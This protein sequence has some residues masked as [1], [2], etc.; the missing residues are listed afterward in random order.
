LTFG[1]RYT[2]DKK[3]NA[4]EDLLMPEL[5]QLG[6]PGNPFKKSW[7]EFTPKLG[8][9]Y[10]VNDDLMFY[11]LYSRGFRAGGFSGRA[12]TYEAASIPYNPE[13]VDNFELGMKSEWLNGRLRFNATIFHMEY[14]DKQEEGSVPNSQGTGQQTVV[15][16]AAQATI[17]GIEIDFN[18][19]VSETFSLNGNL[20]LLDAKFDELIDP[21]TQTDLSHLKLRRAPDLTATIEPVLTFD[22][23][24]GVLQARA[25]WHYVDDMEYTILNSPQTQA[26]AHSTVDASLIYT[27]NQFS[28]SL[29]ALNLT[30]D[31]SWQQGY[32]VGAA[33][34]FAGLWSYT[35]VRPPR[36]Y[37]VNFSYNY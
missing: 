18:W 31:D 9:R 25:A 14:K 1:G 2:K 20:G 26:Q 6:G 13:T 7:N 22:V 24:D 28:V 36:T 15:L 11:G 19:L 3:T 32:D 34:G 33:V 37:G 30:D 4:Y 12:G 21:P 17:Q 29:W 5:A 35:A 27:F 23:G 8:A 10:R 16:N